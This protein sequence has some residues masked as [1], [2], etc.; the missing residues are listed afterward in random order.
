M[1]RGTAGITRRRR[2][3]RFWTRLLSIAGWLGVGA[4]AVALLCRSVGV[5]WQAMIIVAS[6]APLLM[7]CAL[8]GA[9]LLASRRSW[10][11]V[12]I[13][14]VVVLCLAVLQ[15]PLFVAASTPPEGARLVV[16]Q[17]NLG[18]GGADAAALVGNIREL[19][20]DVLTAEELTEGAANR[21]GAAGIGELLPYH[22]LA[23]EAGASGTGIWSR[24]PLID[25]LRHDGFSLGVLSARVA[26]PDAGQVQ[27]FAAHPPP[28]W[29]TSAQTWIAEM[30]GLADVL[31]E[32]TRH[33]S[34]VIAGGDFNATVDHAQF[35]HLLNGGYRDAAEQAGAGFVPTYPTDY[36]FP[37]L[38]TLD[39]VVTHDVVAHAVFS[40]RLPGSDH[41]ALQAE[42]VL[43]PLR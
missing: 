39:H 22:F 4:G 19:H 14:A 30:D 35:R 5:H 1:G 21:L 10:T 29:P 26:V 9:V 43:P 11:A 40:V 42:M 28:P 37:P 2:R 3:G 12:V 27:V 16:L 8:L 38:L 18:L 17:A 36:P 13:G 41:R 25:S 20:V 31:A 34:A 23:A 33:N 7:L 24:Y 15:L 6:F 32:A